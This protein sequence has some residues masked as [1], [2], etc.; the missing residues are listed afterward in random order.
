MLFTGC[1]L[2]N[3]QRWDQ[4]HSCSPGTHNHARGPGGGQPFAP[5]RAAPSPQAP[6][7]PPL[8]GPAQGP[9]S[10]AWLLGEGDRRPRVV[11]ETGGFSRPQKEPW[12]G[13]RD[14]G[15]FKRRQRE[16]H[17]EDTPTDPMDSEGRKQ[18]RRPRGVP[19]WDLRAS[20]SHT[21]GDTFLEGG[22]DAPAC[23]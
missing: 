17:V 16:R 10:A 4:G 20:H 22:P 13:T 21:G 1:S 19:S 6:E 23:E 2:Q 3:Q 7:S 8:R 14:P 9:G 11:Q 15:H 12:P 5:R 18:A